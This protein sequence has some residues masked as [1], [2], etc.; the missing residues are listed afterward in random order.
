MLSKT[1]DITS[2][3]KINDRILRTALLE[4][5]SRNQ[6]L[7]NPYVFEELTLRKGRVRIDIAVISNMLH[8]YEIK[9]NVD[10]LKRLADQLNVYNES[11]DRV[12]L[13]VGEKH[14]NAVIDLIPNW[15]GV[16]L[17][18]YANSN[19]VRIVEVRGAQDNPVLNILA[20]VEML[21]RSEALELLE[22]YQVADGVRSKPNASL[23]ERLISEVSQSDIRSGVVGAIKSRTNWRSGLQRM[24]CG[25]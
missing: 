21:W 5:L 23:F 4:H 1:M 2:L 10:S 15:W 24:S 17:G 13:L 7:D 16:M 3:D 12:T 6:N 20:Y 8:G 14:F 25:D 22:K 9:S 19:K 18:I 11:L